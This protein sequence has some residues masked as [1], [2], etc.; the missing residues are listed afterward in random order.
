M[1]LNTFLVLSTVVYGGFG[2]GL[3]VAPM[4]FVSVF[5]VTLDG[6]GMLMARVLGAALLNLTLFFG[7]SEMR[8]TL[9]HCRRFCVPIAST[10]LLTFQLLSLQF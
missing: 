6:S 5:G 2:L 3:L 10:T 4:P 9:T 7:G 1:K 8:R